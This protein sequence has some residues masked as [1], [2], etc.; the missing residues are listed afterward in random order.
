MAGVLVVTAAAICPC[1]VDGD[2][3]CGDTGED[4]TSTSSFSPCGGT[5]TSTLV[6]VMCCVGSVVPVIS[7]IPL[8]CVET[9]RS[10][11][12]VMLA[13]VSH[14]SEIPVDPLTVPV[15]LVV[16][17]EGLV[18]STD[19]VDSVLSSGV[20]VAEVRP[21]V[22]VTDTWLVQCPFWHV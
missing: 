11:A 10:P 5:S 16:T 12:R 2:R 21:V 3:L 15:E 4:I 20:V 9:S 14:M 22:G 19:A 13:D 1:L 17:S 18:S 7:S 8:C 6:S